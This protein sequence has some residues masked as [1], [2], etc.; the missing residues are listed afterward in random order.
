[1]TDSTAEMNATAKATSALRDMVMR[2]RLMPGQQL[3]QE[4]L[5]DRL[6]L[7]RSPLREALRILETEG[8]VRYV[9]NQ[10]YF[11]AEFDESELRQIYLMRRLL[12]TELL[13]TARRPTEEDL[14]ALRAHNQVVEA[15]GTAG[16]ITQMLVANRRFHFAL[17]G[18][19]PLR[20]VR[21]E[22]ERLWHLSE[23]YRAGYLWLPETRAR[24]V[25]EH[26][27]MIDAL[28]AFDIDRLVHTAEQHRSASEQTVVGLF[29][30]V[31]GGDGESA[32]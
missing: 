31:T 10:G 17:L 9:V 5:A 26:A 24:I 21:R 23:A 4:Q 22:V 6:N 8:L 20:L 30:D 27:M 14:A 18:L 29:A 3:R 19:S 15:G 16:S 7:S 28:A 11:V 32:S 2:R 13:R 1:M 12:E 25:A